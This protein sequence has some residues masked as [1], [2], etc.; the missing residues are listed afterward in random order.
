[1]LNCLLIL[2]QLILTSD[3][4]INAVLNTA[5]LLFI[6]EIDDHL[7]GLLGYNQETIV[8]NY[9]VINL[10]EQFDCFCLMRDEACTDRII[11]NLNDAIGIQFSDYYLTHW[12]EQGS[13]HDENIHFQP[14]E[15]NASGDLLGHQINPVNSVNENCLIRKI[16]WSYTTGFEFSIKPRIAYLRLEMMNGEVVEINMKTID[17]EVGVDDVYHELEGAYIITTF[18]MSSSV[19]RLRLC[20]SYYS[21]DFLKAFEY[22]SLWDI[23]CQARRLLRRF[24]QQE[25]NISGVQDFFNIEKTPKYRSLVERASVQIKVGGYKF[26]ER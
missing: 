10:L 12:P 8:K 3:S 25:M 11:H 19:L 9:L 16:V 20:G 15:V 7:P 2:S 22:Y 21:E 24:H 13:A 5:A 23:N 4:F 6:P 17:D 26:Y 1:M 18:Q 14:H